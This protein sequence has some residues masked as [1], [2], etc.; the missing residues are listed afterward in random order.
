MDKRELDGIQM[1]G[2]IHQLISGFEPEIQMAMVSSLFAVTCRR[3][4]VGIDEATEILKVAEG[5][6]NSEEVLQ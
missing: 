2:M 5:M 6:Q 4:G 3:L 1:T